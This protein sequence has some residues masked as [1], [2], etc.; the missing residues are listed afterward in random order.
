MIVAAGLIFLLD[1]STPETSTY[2]LLYIG[3]V[4]LTIFHRSALF[5]LVV[6]IVVS[7]LTVV[8]LYF[9]PPIDL[10]V[11]W[12]NRTPANSSAR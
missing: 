4:L 6:T 3:L 5:S 9:N 2:S 1:Y 7:V 10:Q 8:E 12:T 11:V